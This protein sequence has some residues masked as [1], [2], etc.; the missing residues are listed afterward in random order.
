[1][2]AARV[3]RVDAPE[4]PIKRLG[5][6]CPTEQRQARRSRRDQA[7]YQLARH[8]PPSRRSGRISAPHD[9]SRLRATV[10]A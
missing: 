5:V 8:D 1:V 7:S 10:I 3:S 2:P 9:A 4:L 6:A